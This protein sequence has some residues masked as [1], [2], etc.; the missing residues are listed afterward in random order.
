MGRIPDGAGAV[1]GIGPLFIGHLRLTDRVI[2]RLDGV[3]PLT[4]DVLKAGSRDSESKPLVTDL[5]DANERNV[6]YAGHRAKRT[7]D[8]ELQIF[9]PRLLLLR[10][11]FADLFGSDGTA[12]FLRGGP[13]MEGFVLLLGLG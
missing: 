6:L 11:L 10:D 3:A 4:A 8:L 9:R 1:Q 7:F 2:E 12:E 5:G 13:Y